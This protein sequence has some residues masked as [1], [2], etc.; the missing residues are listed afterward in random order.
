MVNESVFGWYKEVGGFKLCNLYNMDSYCDMVIDKVEIAP[1]QHIADVPRCSKRFIWRLFQV[2]GFKP[3]RFRVVEKKNLWD[4]A[5]RVSVDEFFIN[6]NDA[7]LLGL[8]VW[9]EPKPH[10]VMEER[11]SKEVVEELKEEGLEI[12]THEDEVD[13]DELIALNYL[14]KRGLETGAVKALIEVV[15][16]DICYKDFWVI[17]YNEG[18]YPVIVF[19]DEPKYEETKKLVEGEWHDQPN[20][21]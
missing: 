9:L 13:K 15:L 20:K 6:E 3:G 4:L 21:L 2:L 10:T 14:I 12:E 11:I 1:I 16:M 5:N 7:K 18:A 19:P 17:V 8:N